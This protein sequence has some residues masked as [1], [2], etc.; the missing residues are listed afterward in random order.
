V[1]IQQGLP[2]GDDLDT[3]RP[4]AGG[5]IEVAP[6]IVPDSRTEMR[7]NLTRVDLLLAPFSVRRQC[8]GID[9][10]AEFYEI[11]VRLARGVIFTGEEIG[12]LGSRLFRF[13]IPKDEFLVEESILDNAPVP[14]PEKVFQKPTEDVTGL[15]DLLNGRVE[16]HVAL[17][18]RLRFRAGCVGDR[19]LIDE[20]KDG[21]QGAD[22]QGSIVA[23]TSDRDGDGVPD[24]IDNCPRTPN[25]SQGPDTTAPNAS[26][27]PSNR[28][29]G[30]FQVSGADDC[31]NPVTLR[32]G[33][34]TLG[35]GEVIQ[36]QETGKPG[37]RLLADRSNDVRH[38]Q[39]GKGEA[40]VRATDMAGNSANAACK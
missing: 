31:S 36:I 22:V 9:A 13:S 10:T 28:L 24:V 8:Q 18:S 11:G 40:I 3:T 21:T 14:Q 19:C 27:V 37:V 26:C 15:I 16:I 2:C 34:F 1:R 12:P 30:S 32:L 23:P 35:N 20:I 38:F 6:A 4:I 29:G 5:R 25:P 17:A 39:V 33:P 7:F